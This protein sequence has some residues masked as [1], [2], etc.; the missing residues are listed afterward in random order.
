[1]IDL[2]SG[3]MQD[4]AAKWYSWSGYLVR[5]YWEQNNG[6]KLPL[7]TWCVKVFCK[8][9]MLREGENDLIMWIG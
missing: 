5:V 6:K 7:K 1:M 4:R 8:R 3:K 9:K 2:Q